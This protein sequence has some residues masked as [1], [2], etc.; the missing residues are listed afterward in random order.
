MRASLTRL[1]ARI[2]ELESK[3]R[4]PT[5]P[6]LARQTAQ[7]LETLDSEFKAHH[8][9]VIDALDDEDTDGLEKEQEILDAHDDDVASLTS[10]IE[11]L[12]ETCS[13]AADSGARKVSSRRLSQF[14]TRLSTVNTAIT[15]LSGDPKEIHLVYL[16]QEQLSDFKKE[17]GD[18]RSE[19][20]S[21]CT[22]EESEELHAKISRLDKDIFDLS[23]II[24]RLLYNPEHTPEAVTPTH[25]ARGVRLPKLEVPT[26]NGNILQ[27][28]TFWEQFCVAIHN[29]SDISDTEKLVYL[30]HS[31]KDGKAKTVI[32]GLSRSG[33]HYEEAIECLQSRYNRPRLIHQAHVKKIIDITPLKEGS[34]KELRRLHDVA[35]QHLRA[36]KAMKQEPSGPFITSL[37]ELKLDSGTMFEWQKSSR[38]STNTP[39]YNDL[40]E[41]IDLRAQASETISS[42]SKSKSVAPKNNFPSKPV[43]SFAAS[44]GDSDANCVLCKTEKHPLYVC[45]QFKSLTH[46]KMLSTLR[47]NG[48]C[49]N[50]LRP[51]HFSRQCPSLNRCRRCQKPHHTLLHLESPPG[52]GPLTPA[53]EPTV[54]S[55]HAATGISSNTLLMTCQVTVK[56]SDGSSHKARALLDSA[57][58]A[59][60]VSERL[61]NCLN[62]PRSR[63]NLKI[64]GVAGLSQQSPLQSIAAFNI[65]PTNFPDKKLTVSAIIVPRVTCDLP[66]QPVHYGTN[67]NHLSG[68]SLADPDFGKPGR[69]D[70]LL[71]VDV[72][73]DVLLNGRRSGPPGTPA[74]FET[75]FGWVLAGRTNLAI[76]ATHSITSHHIA[77][78]SNEDVL[79][80]FWEI[81]EN[82]KDIVALS[83]EERTVV[84]HFQE[85][86]TRND[87]GRF[88][89]PLP[90]KPQ[91]KP[92]GESRSQAVRRF[93]SQER[94]LRSKGQFSE[95]SAVIQEYF[96]MG[97][98]ELV[99]IADLQKPVKDVFYLPMHAVRKEDSTTTK[100]RVVFD[101][102]AKSATGTSLNDLLLVGPTVHPTLV[103]VLLRFR[104]H[105]VA[106]TADVSKMYRAVELT[107]SDRDLHR[108]V[109]RTDP[110]QPLRDYRMTRITFGVSASSYAANMALKQNAINHA[111]Q[112]PLAAQAVEK[113][114]YVDDCLTGADTKEEA[115]K[116][117]T[118]L[119]DLFSCGD[120]LLRKWNS[121]E[122]AVL[123]HLSSELKV[124]QPTKLMPDQDNYTKTLGIQWNAQMDHFRLTVS[125]LSSTADIVI[126]KRMLVSDIAKTFDILGWFSPTTIKMKILLQRLWE[127]KVD[128]DDPVP[129]MI[130]DAWSR[131]RSELPLLAD[132]HIPRC[133]FKKES[134][135]TSLELHGFCDAS[136]LAYG[137]VVYLRMTDS[138]GDI[139]ISLVTSKTKVAPIKRLTIPR[140]EL[141]GAQLLA[142]LLHHIQRV[143]E[144]P[145]N[146]VFA[147][148]DSTIVLSWLVGN[149][150]RFKTYV[151]NRVSYIVDLIGPDRW[152]HVN[153]LE[154]P[155]DCASR[156]LFPS[157][158]LEHPL[159]WNG[160]SWLGLPPANWPKL[161]PLTPNVDLGEEREVTLHA[162]CP[163][164][165]PIIQVDR[166][167]SFT[168]LKRV[169]AWVTRFVKN[170]RRPRERRNLTLNLTTQE[171][172][173][174][175][176]YW[177][178][179]VQK[180]YFTDEVSALKKQSHLSSSSTL[181]SL[182][183]ILDSD[184]L[185]RV[186]G[187]QQNSK[188]LFSV[189][190][191]LILHGEHQ[192]T[193]LIVQTEHVRL[194]HA[195]PTLLSSSLGRR[196]HIIRSRNVIRS[197]TRGCVTCRRHSAKP[198]PQQLGQLPIERITPDSIFDKIGVD[199]AGPMY[200]KHGHVRKPTIVKAYVCVF[201]SL[202]VKAV[203]LELVSDL[204]SQA[205]IAALRRFI[206]RR[207]KPSLIWS[208][209]GTNFTGASR[210]LRDFYDFLKQ[211]STQQ[212]ISEFCSCQGIHWKFIPEHAPHFGG[213]WEAAV[214]SMKMHLRR[215]IS[216]VKLTFEELYTVLTQIESCLNS[217][218]LVPLPSDD[219][220]IEVLT[221]GHFLIGRPLESLPDPAFSYRPL[222]LLSRW[223]LCQALVRHF[224]QR[225]SSEYLSS[226]RR[227]VKWHHPSRNIQV[228]DVVVLL[229]D[230]VS[231]AKWPLARVV[232]THPGRDELIRVVTVKTSSGEYKRPVT[233]VA[234]LLPSS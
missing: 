124:A 112:Y 167:S 205:F 85:T 215:I 194:L 223:Y 96:D 221:P 23:L 27:W 3:V 60:F 186:G 185:L 155:A 65:V 127:L 66:L 209:N 195:G 140:L 53:V 178:S 187:R 26:F 136:E 150:K 166:Y 175:E 182:H 100:L 87:T 103:D 164:S 188:L 78:S 162:V 86:H 20:T 207:G 158:L 125:K 226:L 81:E 76:D 54:S 31:L 156:G 14:E 190:H 49:M 15:A 208:D 82:P 102:S 106:L 126:T 173:E 177:I 18:I 84:Q 22:P 46:D 123:D 163:N 63:H 184:N 225:W 203:H 90:R 138:N 174:A 25:D 13:S 200:I 64:S 61:A 121:S 154:N 43:T 67:W 132:K 135:I 59:S 114:F 231:P 11:R 218:P 137:A 211:Q 55:S 148:T 179:V 122:P 216:N 146:S 57:S 62:L 29:R 159:W 141:C 47:N 230:N 48:H 2:S 99:P 93:L 213:I 220:G 193:K 36:L 91:C 145:L 88:I 52:K 165:Q 107:H 152:N 58:S 92:L 38:E 24:K 147:W 199:Y 153:G 6:S 222:S 134:Y 176:R 133:Y 33:E 144:L 32:E 9:T 170:C 117:Q 149:P 71:G 197:V 74:A 42:E 1:A 89:V 214:K 224:W 10:R 4:E 183:P 5:T 206:S 171:L 219:D 95:F 172:L 75:L 68:L 72:Y 56:S 169:T 128:W 39:H 113:S 79:R 111:T 202:S 204:T 180:Q 97:H 196:Y 160:P 69:I 227:Y 228:G 80:K 157:E 233:K 70:L 210:E 143:F 201:V 217:R 17:L 73:A 120:F 130:Y 129:S 110:N 232:A 118:Q 151:G 212:D 198:S 34:G 139:Q 116:L 181:L 50:C 8:F 12:L 168:C 37:L 115:I 21:L 51:G 44:A 108:F 119:Q 28:Q 7:K 229:E 94:A 192:V 45:P 161:M 19:V 191:P 83:P 40:L 16:Y 105:R 77:V 104:F 142:Q 131:W 98:A 41:F 189:L 35:Q 101:G 234:M 30:R 109:W